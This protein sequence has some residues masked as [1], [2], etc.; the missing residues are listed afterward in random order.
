[1]AYSITQMRNSMLTS[2]LGR[3]IG[4]DW[5]GYLVGPL[6]LRDSIEDITTTAPTSALPHGLTRVLTAGSS[7]MS[8]NTLQPPQIGVRKMLALT[9]TS[10]GTHQ[11]APTAATLYGVNGSS[12]PCVNLQGAGAFVTLFADTTAS[13]R[14]ASASGSVSFTTST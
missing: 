11:F 4:L 14:V 10:T 8:L 5:L 7:Q 3:R 12:A 1:M 9:S 13:W 6:S 2:L